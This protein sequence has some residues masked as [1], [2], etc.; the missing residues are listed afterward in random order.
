M[1]HFKFPQLQQRPKPDLCQSSQKLSALLSNSRLG[2]KT[3]SCC[4]TPGLG[5]RLQGV[6]KKMRLSF[7]IISL[8][9]NMLEGRDIIHWKGGIHSFVW[10]TKTFLY[11]IWEPRYKQNKIGY[12]ISKCLNIGQS[13]CLKICCPILFYFYFGSLILK[14]MGLNFQHAQ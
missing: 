5:L 7:C 10:S 1:N 11:D 9:T 8:V 4:Q 14:E 12:Q 3:R 13:Q 2:P 6:Q